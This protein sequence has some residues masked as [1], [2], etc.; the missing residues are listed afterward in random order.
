MA[1]GGV[2]KEV[3]DPAVLAELESSGTNIPAML[4]ESAV[5]GLTDIAGI[6]GDIATLA[7]MGDL[8][9]RKWIFDKTG[10]DPGERNR[11]QFRFFN[12]L[13]MG[14][15][16]VSEIPGGEE[17]RGYLKQW[18]VLGDPEAEPKTPNEKL[19]AA[20][21]RGATGGLIAGP[22]G[23]IPS[24][25]AG[26][27][28]ELAEQEGAGPLA[29]AGIGLGTAIGA[30]GIQS[31]IAKGAKAIAGAPS[32]KP[33]MEAMRAEGVAPRLLGD[34]MENAN[35]RQAQASLARSF[36]GAE[37]MH[38]A[39]QKTVNEID[40]AVEQTASRY[41][42]ASTAM[43]AGLSIQRGIPQ[44]VTEFRN[45]HLGLL[46][47][48]PIQ[49]DERFPITNSSAYWGQLLAQYGGDANLAGQFTSPKLAAIMDAAQKD[50]LT[51]NGLR[52]QTIK[53]VRSHIGEMMSD[54]AL[55]ANVDKG[56]LKG[57][58]GAL[59]ED[60][61]LAAMSKGPAALKAFERSNEYYRAGLVR[62]E[63]RLQ[64]LTDA[65]IPEQAFQMATS[66]QGKNVSD[67]WALRRSLPKQD[68]EAIPGMFIRQL[69]R[70]TEGGQFDAELFFK[71]WSGLSDSTKNAMFGGTGHHDS[72]QS[73]NRLGDIITKSVAQTAQFTN[74]SNTAGNLY[75]INML[76]SLTGA[77]V[78]YATGET[79][80][81]AL[82]G[83]AVGALGPA[84]AAKLMT[85]PA[86]IKWLAIPA[87]SVKIPARLHALS[88][89]VRSEPDI[90]DAVKDFAFAVEAATPLDEQGGTS[91]APEQSRAPVR[92]APQ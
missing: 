41:S 70:K 92:G 73:L 43:D 18:G 24:A 17:I 57:L 80:G 25:A 35:L 19:M 69:G 48:I 9:A 77:G 47:R 2:V 15:S 74:R 59:S 85:S 51:G 29:Q 28:S 31:G 34:V 37:I 26:A 14:N 1:D 82:T 46:N 55:V 76:S 33:V 23:V 16:V 83:A 64:R 71:R 65:R 12:Q 39:V 45:R 32:N 11:Q 91:T 58:Y 20:G 13:R 7:R 36:G 44:F 87:G 67:L 21:V 8:A 3:T 38:Q 81:D 22:A 56:P 6:P 49:A 62:I 84:A 68:W 10:E 86:F 50:L 60:L 30:G 89:V 75:F 63:D 54:P 72:V 40:R 52:W 78:G 5:K 88:Q 53:T 27:A 61:R 66:G 42:T 4:G 79:T 90:A